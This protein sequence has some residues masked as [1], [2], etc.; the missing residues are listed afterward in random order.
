V[1][2]ARRVLLPPGYGDGDGDGELPP[3]DHILHS[4][5]KLNQMQVYL[6]TA[7]PE[8]LRLYPSVPTD[9]KHVEKDDVL[10]DGRRILKG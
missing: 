4:R 9:F 1:E 10:P 6:Q 8:A 3:E 2:E 7:L 5:E